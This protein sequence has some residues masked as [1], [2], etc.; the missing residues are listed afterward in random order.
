MQDLRYALRALRKQPI[1]TL[2]AVLT[3]TLGIGANAAIF[4]LLYQILLRPLPY[5]DADR[6]VFVWNTYPGI[7][8]P[9][10]SVSIPDYLDRRTQAPALEDATLFMGRT[11][12][13]NEGGNPEQLRALAVTPSFFST[14]QRQPFIGRPFSD[15]DAR[16]EADKFAI[17][18]FALWTSHYASDRGIIGRDIRINGEAYRV[19]GVLPADFE[20]PSRDIALLVPFSFTPQQM[21]DEARGNEF[22][23]MIARLRPG[24]SIP[25]AN[26]QFK[27]IVD[28]NIERLPA[29]AAF[30]K[31]S[32]FGGYAVT[33]RDQIVGDV[34][35]PL[36]VLQASVIV[37]LLI[38]CANVANL[39]LM[40]ATGR[41]RELAI[42][43]TLGAGQWRILRQLLTEGVV[44]SIAGAAGGL[45]LGLIA[46]RALIAM[47]TTQIPGS[48]DA[49]LHP[50]V[51][52]FTAGLALLTGL[53]FG[54]APAVTIARGSAATYLKDD[55]TRGTA[56]KSTG[57][58][59]RMLVIAETALAVVLLV[60]AGLL[61]K[62]YGR[63]QDVNPGFSTENVLTAQI[64]LPASRYPD[65]AARIGF[66]TRVLDKARAIPGVTSSGLTTNVPFNGNIS[67]GSYSIVG[68]NQAPGDPAPHGRQ[69]IVGGEY[70][71]AMRIPLI[72][73]R[74]FTDG[75]T[76]D[77]P[78]VVVVDEYLVKKY[79][80][81]RSPLG[82]QI[83]RGGPASPKFTIVGVVG[84]INSIDLGQPVTKER[85]YY[86]ATQQ[87]P[88]AMALVLKTG[89]DPQALVPQVRAAVREL[90][91][92]QPIADVRTLDQW[93]AR[94]LQNRR[95]P[96]T[97]LAVFGGVA[98]LLSAIG[99]Y[100]VL[101]FGVAQRVREFGIRQALG[102]DRGSILSLVLT[103]GLKTAGAG[104][105][106]GVVLA[107]MVTRYLQ[108]LLFGVTSRDPMV[109]A[110]VGAV[111]L[112]VAIVACYIPARRATEVDPM[113]A[114]R[115][116]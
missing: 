6:L 108:A 66:W 87:A 27:T 23:S 49:A 15:D 45:V 28:R 88:R 36:Y 64:A 62:S 104:I 107:V 32:G 72:A 63:L 51:L 82:Q 80:A 65:D 90:D 18:T 38:A 46:V 21:S 26:A 1:F 81:D 52:L 19:V 40:R 73:G 111:L 53:V 98:L 55:S 70:F 92:E 112:S 60:C 9:Q 79:F 91:P 17:L 75:D 61:I 47:S 103:E 59:R 106:I 50:A 93:I 22:S 7:N 116:A 86:P 11:A 2:V 84:T 10:A 44:L 34:R 71:K 115:E 101:A 76:P 48:P 110:G 102:A 109:F 8:L 20:L 30:A 96:T 58:T 67:S 69:E 57:I 37:V 56:G 25:L 97:L 5:P 100:G 114:L 43:S 89:L 74:T 4:S 3:L 77:A 12:N 42:R 99:I 31:S 14:L 54:I 33:M 94:S 105:L 85:I 83:Q 95:T 39:L 35:S 78:P 68:L 41:S 13:L 24:A 29:R 16:P 113:V